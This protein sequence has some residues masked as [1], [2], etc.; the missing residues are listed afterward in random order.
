MKISELGEKWQDA[1][2]YCILN[3]KAKEAMSIARHYRPKRIY[4]YFSFESTYWKKNAKG[5]VAFCHPSS[6]N[7]PMDSRWFLNY[8]RIIDMRFGKEGAAIELVGGE[9]FSIMKRGYETDFMW[10]QDMFSVS[11][12]SLTP[13]SNPMW[14]HYSSKH[15]G[16][17]VE[18]DV[19]KMDLKNKI[20][21]PV[22]YSDTPFD[23]SKLV[24]KVGIDDDFSNV[25]PLVVKSKDWIYEKEWRVFMQNI[26]ENDVVVENMQSA[27]T[28]IYFGLKSIGSYKRTVVESWAKKQRIPCYQIERDYCSFELISDTI[29]DVREG[30]I[31]GF[32]L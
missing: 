7:D 15:F 19:D 8:E 22:L 14:G 25:C 1:Y 27:I 10:L 12:F 9:V 13:Y 28:G 6:F 11:C 23:A 18:Y 30:K 17:C 20:L 16:F 4:K 31:K 21:A 29:E 24:D 5:D 3:F 32:I 2:E 26:P